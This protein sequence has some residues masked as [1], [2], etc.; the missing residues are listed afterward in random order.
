MKNTTM[1]IAAGAA[2][3]FSAAA[4]LALLTAYA[5]GYPVHA[6]FTDA[7]IVAKLCIMAMVPAALLALPGA[8]SGVRVLALIGAGLAVALGVL[9]AA[10]VEMNVQAAIR[11]VGPVSFAVTAPSRACSTASPRAATRRA[12]R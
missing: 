5:P 8:L 7:D 4:C 12:R 1:L 11:A 10:W 2:F 3:A 6:L 9:G